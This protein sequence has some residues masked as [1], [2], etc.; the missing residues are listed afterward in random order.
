MNVLEA[1][2]SVTSKA[3][4]EDHSTAC[5]PNV[6]GN[7]SQNSTPERVSRPD[8]DDSLPA[9]SLNTQQ[10]SDSD[11][12]WCTNTASK[13]KAHR[14]VLKN[15]LVW[16]DLEMTGLDINTHTIMEVA[17]IIT[18]G[19]V[20]SAVEG[21]TIAIQTSQEDLE[22]MNDWCKIHHVQSGL[23]QKCRESKISLQEAEKRLLDFVMKHVEWQTAQ[24]AGNSVHIDRMF[25]DKYMPEFLSYLNYRIVDVSSIK[26]LARRWYPN[27]YRKAPKKTMAHTALSDIRESIA[28]LRYYKK[29]IFRPIGR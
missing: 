18:D 2:E 25:L 29:A 12:G 24:L 5:S 28:E 16:I 7:P 11:D 13:A 23:A 8:A 3:E 15:P 1:S 10:A 17:V 21:P 6:S 4:A 22:N 9:S 19:D 27:Q 26:E 20:H 14:K